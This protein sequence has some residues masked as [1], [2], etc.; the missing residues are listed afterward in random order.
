M[1]PSTTDE[2]LIA[3]CALQDFH[4][5]TSSFKGISDLSK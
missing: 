1:Y 2:Y 4:K 5:G 3:F